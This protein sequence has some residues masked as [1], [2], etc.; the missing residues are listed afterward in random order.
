MISTNGH[1]PKRAILYSRVSTDEQARSGYSLAQQIEA[2]QAYAARE[3]Y[4][5]LE[6]VQDPGQSGASLERPGM[7]RVRDLVASGGVSAVLAQ[8]RDRF[9]REPAYHYLLRKEF[10]GYGTKIRALND[11]GDGSPEA[12][13]TDGILDQLAKYERAKVVERSRRGKLRKAREGKVIATYRPTHG[14]RI[15]AARDGYEVDEE[16]MAVVRRVFR[17]VG[18]EG[19]GIYSVHKTLE[20]EGVPAPGGGKYWDKRAVK[21]WIL[22]DAYRPHTHE[23]ISRLVRPEVAAR[24]DP[25]KSY[26]VWWF[27]R[28]RTSLTQVSEPNPDGGGRVYRKV[29]KVAFR[30]KDEWIAVPVPDA[31]IPLE[32]VDA[33]RAMLAQGR[34]PSK[35]DG[36]FWELSGA[37]MRCGECGRA[38]EAMVKTARKKSGGKYVF[39]YYRCREGNRRRETCSNNKCI[40]SDWAHA[41]VWEL[42]SGLLSEPERLREGL[43]AMIEE[44]RKGLR[45]DPEHESKHWLKKLAEIESKRDGYLE[46]AAEGFMRREELRTKLAA[47]EETRETAGRE[48]QALKGRSELLRNLQREKDTIMERYAGMVPEALETLSPQERHRVYRM[49]RLKVVAHP[50]DTMEVQGVFG[51]RFLGTANVLQTL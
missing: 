48:L 34:S 9:T 41:A 10:E 14:F 33:S 12:E 32:W 37:L 43:E 19:A 29:E 21:R 25:Q 15:N 30:D 11:R 51:D 7:D 26:G 20:R 18:A 4:E 35:V 46:L 27:N 44:E 45:G 2:L 31:G 50:D 16:K 22:D 42:V 40:R 49:L 3:G 8:D 47:L 36:R 17:M 28:R 38:M 39:C 13:L 24:L 23:E 1:G 5:V 6:E